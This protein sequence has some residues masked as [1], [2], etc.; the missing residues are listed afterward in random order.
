MAFAAGA[1][2]Q[3]AVTRN[4]GDTHATVWSTSTVGCLIICPQWNG[5]RVTPDEHM[6]WAVGKFGAVAR[7]VDGGLSFSS[8]D[9]TD[10]IDLPRRYN[11]W[12]IDVSAAPAR[13]LHARPSPPPPLH[14][15]SHGLTPFLCPQNRSAR[16]TRRRG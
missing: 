15:C 8:F 11:L 4:F 16:P 6:G 7:T 5:I 12:S 14:G 9:V 13:L 3:L 10:L 1:A 2:G